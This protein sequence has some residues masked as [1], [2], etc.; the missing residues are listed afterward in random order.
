MG[1]EKRVLRHRCS[2]KWV[3]LSRRRAAAAPHERSPEKELQVQPLGPCASGERGTSLAFLIL[4]D[5]T[6]ATSR[7]FQHRRMLIKSSSV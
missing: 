6:L 2:K 5:L 7:G 4:T 3:V 1:V